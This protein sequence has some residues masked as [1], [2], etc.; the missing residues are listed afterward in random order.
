M[1]TD[2]RILNELR[3]SVSNKLGKQI[4]SSVHCDELSAEINKMGIV[5]NPQTFRRFFGLIKNSGKFHIYTLDTLAQYCNFRDYAD[6]KKGLIQ[7]EIDLFLENLH[8]E[9][10][11]FN[12]W[13]LSETICRKIIDSPTLLIEVQHQLIK[14]PL[15]RTFFME[16]H[17]LRDLA[18]TVYVQY[19]QDYLKFE[20]SN[21]AKLFAFGFLYMGAFLTDN[22]EFKFLYSERIKN[23]ELTSEVYVL[24]AGR[25]FG[26]LLLESW[27]KKDKK[28]FKKIYNQMLIARENY[29]H[30]SEK[31]VCSFEYAVL[32]HLIFTDETEEMRF[33]IENNTFQKYN[34]REFVPQDRKENHDVCWNIMCAVAYLKMKEHSKCE[35]YL[36]KVILE[37]LSLGWKKYY[38][39]LFYFVKYEFANDK[40]RITIKNTLEKLIDETH[41]TFY[42]KKV[43]KLEI[44]NLKNQQLRKA[45]S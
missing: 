25:K 34:D 40:E 44:K 41:F 30:I 27:S 26:V 18:G 21:E 11:D 42:L 1:N 36:N 6:F 22:K 8:T 32:E 19:F 33:L 17:P 5:I 35:Q 37:N 10:D 24:P 29:T 28:D 14:Y 23:I 7:N 38:S 20:Q 3:I 31:S 4:S 43:E 39:I 13:S 45:V 15:A 2:R 9:T 16:H 12:Y